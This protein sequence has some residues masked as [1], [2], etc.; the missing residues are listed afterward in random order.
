LSK[1]VLEDPELNELDAV[2]EFFPA[3][4]MLWKSSCVLRMEREI[5]RGQPEKHTR[6]DFNFYV[7][8]DGTVEIQPRRRDAPLDLLVAEWMIY[9]NR[10]WGGM[11]DECKVTGIYRV[12][13]PMGRVRRYTHAAP[14]VG[15]GCAPGRMEYFAL[16]QVCGFG[17][18]AA[19]DFT[20]A[21][22]PARLHRN[23]R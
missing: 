5:V 14:H 18:P 7:S 22:R 10:E 4:K 3:L 2:G 12:Q 16:A 1:E 20:A 21:P 17:E 23:R 11:R 13:P 15:F 19:I 8:D 9:V 6:I